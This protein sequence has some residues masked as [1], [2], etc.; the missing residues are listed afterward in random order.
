MRRPWPYP[1]AGPMPAGRALRSV[2]GSVTRSRPAGVGDIVDEK[3]AGGI[4][5]GGVQHHLRGADLAAAVRGRLPGHVG[6]HLLQAGVRA[7]AETDRARGRT[8]AAA[9]GQREDC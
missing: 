2:S 4:L 8:R 9:E 3:V 6:E 1:L 5:D 7:Q